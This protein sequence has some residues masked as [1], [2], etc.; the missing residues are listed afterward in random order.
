ML[1]LTG[2]HQ[3]QSVCKCTFPADHVTQML[4]THRVWPH[5][6]EHP[7][8]WFSWVTQ[9]KLQNINNLLPVCSVTQVSFQN[10]NHK[11]PPPPAGDT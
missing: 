6:S 10:K 2:A 11:S 1:R 7:F 3:Q 5:R 9:Q 8:V 4:L